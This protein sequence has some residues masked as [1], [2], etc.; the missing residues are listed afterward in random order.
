MSIAAC[1]V[2]WVVRPRLTFRYEC[3]HVA[4]TMVYK[5]GATSGVGTGA[6]PVSTPP[7]DRCSCLDPAW[8]DVTA[9]PPAGTQPAGRRVRT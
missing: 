8:C 9:H 5:A 3:R 6:C 7:P 1:A 2:I 4:A